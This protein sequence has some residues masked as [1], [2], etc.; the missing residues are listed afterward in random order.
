MADRLL[1]WTTTSRCSRAPRAT[2]VD[3]LFVNSFVIVILP[4]VLLPLLPASLAAYAF[5][6]IDF[7]FRNALFVAVFALQIVLLQIALPPGSRCS[8]D[9]GPGGQNGRSGCRTAPSR[10][11]GGVPTVQ[12]REG[13]SW[14]AARAALRRW[15]RPRPI[16]FQVFAAAHRPRVG[17]PS[18]SSSSSGSGTTCLVAL[19]MLGGSPE[20]A[21]LTMI[22]NTIAEPSA[23][24][25]YLLS[26]AAF[27]LDRPAGCGVPLPALLSVVC[28]REARRADVHSAR[29]ARMFPSRTLLRPGVSVATVS[30]ALRGGFDRVSRDAREV[31]GSRK[32]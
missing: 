20:L 14:P 7:L 19:T 3:G 29:P 31:L 8:R 5:A 12:L 17:V 6:W 27:I 10:A 23:T 24:S 2:A 22:L 28:S 16:F 18:A 9:H 15:R 13:G 1:R 21:P 4:A 25:W 30:R 32:S 26:A 11:A